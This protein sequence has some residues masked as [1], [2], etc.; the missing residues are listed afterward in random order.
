MYGSIFLA[1]C[2]RVYRNPLVPALGVL[3]LA[4]IPILYPYVTLCSSV[5][6]STIKLT[7]STSLWKEVVSG[8]WVGRG[9]VQGLGRSIHK[10]RNCSGPCLAVNSFPP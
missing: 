7:A 10:Y 3:C 8:G 9:G 4:C 5:P 1:S 6:Y 2:N